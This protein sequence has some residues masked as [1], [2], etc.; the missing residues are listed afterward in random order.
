MVC[1]LHLIATELDNEQSWN[2]ARDA[3]R[4]VLSLTVKEGEETKWP[5]FIGLQ[6]GELSR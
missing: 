4:A 1:C 2:L 3:T 6:V 5:L